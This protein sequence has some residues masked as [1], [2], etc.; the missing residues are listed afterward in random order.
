LL[1]VL[2]CL[3]GL[4]LRICRSEALEALEA[5]HFL[6]VAK[7]KKQLEDDMISNFEEYDLFPLLEKARAMAMPQVE[8]ECMRHLQLEGYEQM[9][10]A[11]YELLSCSE[12]TFKFVVH[13]HNEQRWEDPCFGQSDRFVQDLVQ[14]YCRHNAYN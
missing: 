4:E 11:K 9:R 1:G 2:S 10:Y 12:G 5:I 6:K 7:L 3:Y 13:S 8:D 14:E